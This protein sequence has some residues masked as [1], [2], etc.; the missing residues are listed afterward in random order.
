VILENILYDSPHQTDINLPGDILSFQ[1]LVTI[2]GQLNYF[3]FHVFKSLELLEDLQ[4]H[5]LRGC[6]GTRNEFSGLFPDKNPVAGC[7]EDLQ[8]K[9]LQFFKGFLVEKVILLRQI[10]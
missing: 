9:R 3:F 2:F 8:V 5:P 6:D 1:S 10:Y 4:P 7:T